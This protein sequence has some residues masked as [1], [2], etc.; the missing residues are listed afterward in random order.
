MIPAYEYVLGYGFSLLIPTYPLMSISADF[1]LALANNA[2]IPKEDAVNEHRLDLPCL[3]GFIERFIY[4][5]AFVSSRETL[6]GVW[7]Q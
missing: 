7:L 1:W 6:I 5:A 2:G 3:V 4:T